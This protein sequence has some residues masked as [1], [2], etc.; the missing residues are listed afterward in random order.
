MERTYDPEE[1]VKARELLPEAYGFDAGSLAEPPN[2]TLKD[3]DNLGLFEYESPG[4]F[5]GHY[6][7]RTPGAYDRA[8]AMISEMFSRHGAVVIKGLT[9]VDNI[10]ALR[11]TRR[12]GFTSHGTVE[13]QAGE[14]ELF[15]LTKDDV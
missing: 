14:M 9:P 13:T 1:L 3:G 5:S 7:F 12:L 11:L 2:V 6:F 10:P 15:T 4:V 8:K